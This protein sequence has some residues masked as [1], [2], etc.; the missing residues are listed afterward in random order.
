MNLQELRSVQTGERATDT[1]QHLRETF[2]EDVGEYIEGL[3][4]ER[5]DAAAR[6]EDPFDSP[7]V[8]RLT[9]EI[10]T[11]E[12]V[13]EAVYE[14]RVG[15][16]VK[17]ASIEAAGMPTD[18][19]E[20]LTREEAALF[21]DLVERIEENKGEVLDVLAGEETT[22]PTGTDASPATDAST[23]SSGRD[24]TPT[25]KSPSNQR[26]RTP[27]DSPEPTS[28]PEATEESADGE[29][30]GPERTTVRITRH[31]GE[32]FGVDER[33]YVL[34]A[35]DVVALPTAN[36]EPLVARDAAEKLE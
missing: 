10:K 29:P 20:G 22:V 17:R 35:E 15:K 33:E 13:V 26:S 25:S 16:I 12:E 14:R 24:A 9:D 23:T 21:E 19:D 1:L 36:A 32:I 2:Y 7:A 6:A 11:A 8:R 3:R 30:N 34:E 4:E 31:V 27:A 5:A 18:E 28:D